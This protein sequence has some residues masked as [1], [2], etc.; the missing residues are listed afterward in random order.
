[1]AIVKAIKVELTIIIQTIKFFYCSTRKKNCSTNS[2]TEHL[3]FPKYSLMCSA[4]QLHL[5]LDYM[6]FLVEFTKLLFI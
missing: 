1:M 6:L 5:T 4:K 2:S 3:K